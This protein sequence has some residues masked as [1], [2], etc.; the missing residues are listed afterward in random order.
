MMKSAL[1]LDVSD[2]LSAIRSV[3]ISDF[4]SATWQVVGSV[5]PITRVSL[6]IEGGSLKGLVT[7]GKRVI[8]WGS[9]TLAPEHIR[10]G[11]I[12]D[13]TQVGL[14]IVALLRS[15]KV[16]PKKARMLLRRNTTSLLKSWKLKSLKK[17]RRSSKNIAWGFKIIFLL[18]AKPLRW[19]WESEAKKQKHFPKS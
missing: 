2:V 10:D 17:L 11:Y 18:R 4:L 5:L 15:L 13:E 16:K 14:Q 12:L 7:R 3:K 1:K 19:F 8:R 9:I 6:S